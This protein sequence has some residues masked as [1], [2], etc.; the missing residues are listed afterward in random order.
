[1]TTTQA[2]SQ[3]LLLQ[4]IDPARRA[5]PYPLYEQIR[6]AGPLRP[7]LL[8][9]TV[10]SSYGD[11]HALLRDPRA[12]SDR[13]KSTLMANHLASLPPDTPTPLTNPPFL[14]LDPPDHTR[15][16][17]LAIKAFTPRVVN[18]LAPDIEKMVDDLLDAAAAR[19]SLEVI[20]DFAYPLPVAVICRLL[21][22]PESDE[23]L[24]SQWSGLM[25]QLLD[26]FMALTGQQSEGVGE[27]LKASLQMRGYFHELIERRRT[28]PSD[29][30]LSALIAAEE[31]GDQLSSEELVSTC[32]LLLIAGH[33]TTVNLIA[34]TTLA[35]LRHP[36]EW[37]KLTATPD[38]AASVVEESLRYDPPVHMVVRTATE[39]MTIGGAHVVGGD[40][41]LLLLA[42]AQRDPSVVSQPAS[43][44]PDRADI[45]H[46]AFGLGPHFCLGAP[47]ARLEATVAIQRLTKRVHG[48]RLAVDPPPYK[49][50]LTLRGMVELRVDFDSFI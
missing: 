2:D 19:Q 24:F 39:D 50:N 3:S 43:F 34:N 13:R 28:T 5:D 25:A 49:E 21:G 6:Q 15:L 14:F 9:V 36:A 8:P 1:M 22:V 26:P 16:R 48:A 30:L 11:C 31:S 10:F 12:S 32:V 42:A 20:A 40:S 41:M 33:E 4:M 27:R 35:L 17:R 45:R 7:Q 37:D 44:D 46:L 47:L 38:R 18:A 23:A 29:D